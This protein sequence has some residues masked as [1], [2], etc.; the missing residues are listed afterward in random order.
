[1][2]QLIQFLSTFLGGFLVAF[3]KGWKLTLVLLAAIPFMAVV[4]AAVTILIT[5][6]TSQGQEAYAQAGDVVEQAISS[7][8]TV[9]SLPHNYSPI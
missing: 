5:K 7:I 9:C 2:G 6:A 3:I 1:M 8:R 4:G